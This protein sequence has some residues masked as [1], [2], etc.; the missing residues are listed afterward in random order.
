[1]RLRTILIG[2]A[3]AAVIIL[4]L[5][6][7]WPTVSRSQCVMYGDVVR[8]DSATQTFYFH[9]DHTYDDQ[10]YVRLDHDLAEDKWAIRWRLSE[11]STYSMG[12]LLF[13][14]IPGV[15][16][17]YIDNGVQREIAMH[18]WHAIDSGCA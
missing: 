16:D 5:W 11:D 9:E 15:V 14:E 8:E 1:M 6:F 2:I 18:I 4:A 17:S 10:Y 13:D 12:G 7:L 3:V